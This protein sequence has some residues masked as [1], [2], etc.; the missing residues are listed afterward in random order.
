MDP[1]EVQRDAVTKQLLDK[2]ALIVDRAT[3][4]KNNHRQEK[5]SDEQDCDKPVSGDPFR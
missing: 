4:L 2:R 1:G 3:L 5:I